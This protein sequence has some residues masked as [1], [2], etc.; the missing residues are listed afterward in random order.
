MKTKETSA[1]KK[2]WSDR[3]KHM[4]MMCKTIKPVISYDKGYD[5]CYIGFRGNLKCETTIEL[6]NDFRL[7]VTKKGEII[8]IE[9]ENMSK[10]MKENKI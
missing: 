4:K 8:G 10:H 6:T 7:D 2:F 9:I 3:K 1:S 5:I